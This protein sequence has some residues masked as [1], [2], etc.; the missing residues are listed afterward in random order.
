MVFEE[1]FLKKKI[2]LAQL[3]KTEPGLFNQFKS[4]YSLMGEKSFDHTKKY[5]FNKLRHSYPLS[6]EEEAK[7]KEFY[8]GQ[9]AVEKA[10]AVAAEA[11]T[12]TA[13]AKPSGFK[14]KFTPPVTTNKTEE[15]TALPP[16]ETTK[17]V[18]TESTQEAKPAGFK[19]RF[20]SGLTK[21]ADANIP[22][23][24]Q[25]E[26]SKEKTPAAAAK[27]SGFK[28]RFKAGITKSDAE[29]GEDVKA[30]SASK[31]ADT[32]DGEHTKV[33]KP[34]GFKPRFKPGVTK[35]VQEE[36]ENQNQI[37]RAQEAGDSKEEEAVSKPVG[38]K[39]RFKPGITKAASGTEEA[40]TEATAEDLNKEKEDTATLAETEEIP[41][42]EANTS[43][44]PLGFKPR[45][46]AGT[47]TVV[48]EQ[49]I[50]HSHTSQSVKEE[51]KTEIAEKTISD[52]EGDKPEI[53]ATNKPLGFKPRFKPGKKD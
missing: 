9:K 5:W 7:L 51:V 8:K 20:K 11:K 28:P 29:E 39:P 4:H 15:A 53:P 19:P 30:T 21:A 12:E 45:F 3:Q 25:P 33:P 26:D 44:K 42:P 34:M 43:S 35:T 27:P 24:Q 48:T 18:T 17:D 40:K 38:F 1:F 22:E 32:S 14:P 6:A 50:E 36:V 41:Q 52:E 31:T 2:D 16:A 47:T 49:K 46:K 10:E 23:P 37:D 13:I